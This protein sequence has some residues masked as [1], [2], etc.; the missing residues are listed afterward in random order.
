MSDAAPGRDMGDRD[1]VG[2]QLGRPARGDIRVA[3]RCAFG[4]PLVVRTPPVLDDGTPF[5][6]HYYLT[7][8]VAVRDIGRLEASGWMSELT[9]RL[10]D[11]P[12]FAADYR[13]AHRRYRRDRDGHDDGKPESAGG[14]PGR[15]KCL[16]ALYAHHKGDANPVGALVAQRIEPIDC[17]GP[18]VT[19]GDDGTVARTPGHPGFKGK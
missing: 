13:D 1:I 17:P 3:A 11:D 10:A 19:A 14:M 18:C 7:C 5:P 9:Q 6:T 8:P 4:L 2:V 16:H 15:V 12:A